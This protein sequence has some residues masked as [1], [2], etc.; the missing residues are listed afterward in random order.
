M[1][2]LN[3]PR[4]GILSYEEGTP[5]PDFSLLDC[6]D[7]V[8]KS[9]LAQLYI[10]KQLN[11]ISKTFYSNLQ[12]PPHANGSRTKVTVVEA[13]DLI[14]MDPEARFSWLAP[15][16]RFKES[17]PP[18]YDILAARLRAKYWGFQVICLRPFIKTILDFS[19]GLGMG[20]LTGTACFPETRFN[21]NNMDAPY[22]TVGV[23]SNDEINPEIV[24]YAREGI[25][26]LI[27]STQ[28][29][30]NLDHERLLLTN[31]FGTAIA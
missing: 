20:Q 18:A 30:H 12:D 15:E 31:F 3:L 13:R 22:I 2:E 16:Y 27:E 23:K 28:A 8:A 29:F 1:V 4:S 9:Y 26:A 10:R 5:Y 7:R 14:R 6:E 25:N 24:Q 21:P 17:D 19:F 11:Y